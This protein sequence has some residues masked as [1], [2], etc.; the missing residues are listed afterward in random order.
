MFKN[1][2]L[3]LTFKVAVRCP[4]FSRPR[5]FQD[6]D[7]PGEESYDLPVRLSL[8]SYDPRKSLQ[9]I[10]HF[11]A[12]AVGLP[13]SF[14]FRCR[15]RANLPDV[16][17]TITQRGKIPSSPSGENP[18]VRFNGCSLRRRVLRRLRIWCVAWIALSII[19]VKS[20]ELLLS[21]VLGDW[22]STIPHHL[23]TYTP[24]FCFNGTKE[25]IAEFN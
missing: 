4:L 5:I 24:A 25:N 11:V 22:T 7:K 6:G 16:N 1:L 17:R 8:P 23:F 21:D 18:F 12:F 15:A 19:F 9:L 20:I 14:P 13:L 10:S 3:Y 2:K